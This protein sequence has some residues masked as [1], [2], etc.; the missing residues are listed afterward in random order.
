MK[1]YIFSTLQHHMITKRHQV[2][3]NISGRGG[4]R[5]IFFN[6]SFVYLLYQ[7]ISCLSSF[8]EQKTK[9]SGIFDKNKKHS[10]PYK[11]SV[12]PSRVSF[13]LRP[14]CHYAM[15]SK[16]TRPGTQ[17]QNKILGLLMPYSA[18]IRIFV[19]C[20]VCG[21]FCSG[22]NLQTLLSQGEGGGARIT[23]QR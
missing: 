15:S 4:G 11:L 9:K 2:T 13:S 23:Y 17:K 1:K 18:R 14:P 20:F 3:S 8:Y 22:G 12:M 21:L 10:F 7:L 5:Q 6:H 19:S 16:R